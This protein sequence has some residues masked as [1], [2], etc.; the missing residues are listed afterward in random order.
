MSAVF[1]TI[2]SS[3][4]FANLSLSFPR[5][6]RLTITNLPSVIHSGM[7]VRFQ[8][9][10]SLAVIFHHYTFSEDFCEV[11]PRLRRKGKYEMK[12]RKR[13]K[14]RTQ[15]THGKRSGRTQHGNPHVSL[16]LSP[17]AFLSLSLISTFR[18]RRRDT[19]IR[20]RDYVHAHTLGVVDALR[21]TRLLNAA[22]RTSRSKYNVT[23]D[24]VRA[25]LQNRPRGSLLSLSL[26]RSHV[27]SDVF[28]K[29][30]LQTR[31]LNLTSA[32]G[33][34]E[35]DKYRSCALLGC[36]RFKIHNSKIA[37]IELKKQKR[38]RKHP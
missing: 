20:E 2:V 24:V 12:Q 14:R 31:C 19:D 27:I 13:K 21:V 1:Q 28:H 33:R 35:N 22:T 23:L 29:R 8:K 4:S 38:K 11:D 34:R 30:Y 18:S 16:S 7:S 37:R 17:R 32:Q 5:V 15:K 10:E 36:T 9:L 25:L 6:F 3:N 26:A